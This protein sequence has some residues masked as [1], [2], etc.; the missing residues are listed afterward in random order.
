MGCTGLA[1]LRQFLPEDERYLFSPSWEHHDNP[2]A[3][4]DSVPGNLGHV[5]QTIELWLGRN[6]EAMD[7]EEY[8]YLSG[9]LQA[10]GLKE[11]IENYRRR[12]FS[13]SSAIFWMYNDSW[14]VTNGWT[15]VDYY[16]RTKLAYHP[17]RRANQPVTVTVAD[18]GDMITV[19]G[20]NDTPQAWSGALR[21]GLFTLAGARPVDEQMRV[22]IPANAA[23][24]LATLS[25]AQWEAL[26]LTQSGAFAVLLDGGRV[27]AQHRLFLA[28][29]KDLAFAQPHITLQRDGDTLSLTSDAFAWG[30]CLDLDGERPLA[31]NCIDLLPGIPYTLPWSDAC[32]E[33]QIL[34]V[35]NPVTLPA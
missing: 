6:P 35:G 4:H 29:F 23:V 12:M 33:P 20:V 30:V 10:D 16:R 3:C 17:V 9:L 32:G 19:Y 25:R 22:E 15:I 2:F 11:Y 18:D 14:P 24:A 21:Y 8:A 1:T 5:Y 13:T 27:H 28:R 31:D 7:M 34:R 26:G